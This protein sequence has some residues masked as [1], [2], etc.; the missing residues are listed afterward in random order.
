MFVQK[1]M[2]KLFFKLSMNCLTDR[3]FGTRQILP[4]NQTKC[5]ELC[6]FKLNNSVNLTV[7]LVSIWNSIWN[8]SVVFNECISI[9][10]CSNCTRQI[11]ILSFPPILL[12]SKHWISLK[13]LQYIFALFIHICIATTHN[14]S[15]NNIENSDTKLQQKYKHTN[16]KRN[17]KMH[18]IYK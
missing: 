11:L 13:C 6:A 16:K 7:F 1:I 15:W 8:F 4:T 12:G 14:Q 5:S 2:A 10:I 18:R 3:S 17:K 9:H